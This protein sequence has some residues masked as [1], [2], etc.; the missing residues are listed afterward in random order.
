MSQS[1]L[2][3]VSC[4]LG[5]LPFW[6]LCASSAHRCA[7]RREVADC[8]HLKLT[9]IPD[10]LPANITVLNLT[11]NQLKKLPPANFTRYSQLA[12][13]D[14][15]FNS[16]SKLEP[17]LCQK[18]PLLEILNIQHNELSQVSDKTF[19]FC[20]NLTEL[21]LR[22]NSIQKI[23]NNPFKNLK[24]LIKLDLSH[25]GVPSTKL[26]TE[27]QLQNLQEL[28]LS[29]N[30]INVLTREELDFLGNSSL[31][32]LELSSNPIKEFTPG[33]FHAI[34]K[35]FGLS[36]NNVQLGPSLTEKL[37]LQ[38]ANTSIQNLFLSNTQLSRT[39]NVTFAGLKQTN[40]T[41]LDL[42]HNSLN[43][44]GNDSFAWLPHLKYLFLEY[45]N[46]GHLSSRS[47]YGLSNVRYLNLRRSFTKQ[48]NSLALL[49]KIDDFSFQWL[50][51]LEYLNLE[52]NNFPGTKSNMFTGLI[53]L[54]YLSLSNSFTSFQTLTNETFVS[55]AH[56]PLLMLNL[57]RN[58][59]SKMEGGA[60]SW[61][62][63]LKVL[64]LGINEIG[65]E[66]TGEEWRGLDNIVEIYLSYNKYL[67]LTSTSFTLVPS[68]QQLMLRRVALRIAAPSPFRPLRNLTI[69]DLSNN[70]IANIND[71]LLEGLEKLEILDL[72]HNNL[73]RLWKHANPGGPVLFLKGLSHL[74]ILNLE[75]NGFDE[76]PVDVFKDLFQLK[77]IHLGLNNLNILPPSVF[78]DQASLK[79]LSLQKNLITSV[80]KNVFGPAFKNLSNLD[81]SFNP[82]D[83][84][85]ESIAWFVTWINST[86]TNISE[87]SSHYL[88]NTPPQYHGFPVMLFDVSPCKDSAPF[89]LFFMI[90]TSILLI[91]ISMVLFI[92]LEGWRLSFYW[93]VFVHRALGF[94]EM[95]RQPEQF[96]YAAY[97][98]HAYEDRDWVWEHFSPMEE[99]DQTLRF[100]LEERDFQ[101][102]VLELEA[103]VN[104]IK[105][106][107]KTIFVITQ[108]LLKDPLCK[109]FKVHQAVQKAIEQNLDSIILIFLEEI[110]DYKLNHAL[111]LRRGMFK[112]HCILNWPVQVE[113]MNAFH[114]KLQ[115]AL[116]SRNSV[117]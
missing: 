62:G 4:F 112:S 48:S 18:L 90:S 45:N 58:K 43:M 96:D 20:V 102:G 79:S 88:C 31:K 29:N 60:F 6:M 97:I 16:I 13:L 83:C 70:N 10:D 114:H 78:D 106:S 33:C 34:G 8:S 81:M 109:R 68:L 75:S 69:L 89:E 74:H 15:G 95:D 91:F 50:T 63:A 7:V 23:Q 85:C 42:S 59:I 52:D 1:L 103:I 35:L 76:I 107:R 101:A 38:L 77:S 40:L 44:I 65:Q 41:T 47:F 14:A 51:C 92:H 111:C 26:G 2:H 100:C 67:Q 46:I 116:G 37:C 57:S 110:P 27:L 56:S 39:S 72:Q 54:K 115:V 94:K 104:S 64:D 53:K 21:H 49:P 86:H 98:I 9:Q 28:L 108:N 71:D 22:S 5:L 82:F 32:K 105:R 17:E 66:L 36:L 24:N 25:N 80:E 73:A 19:I 113:R 12:I 11:H 99:K 30:K 117:H 61:L 93:N 84:T 3:P 55:L 87:L